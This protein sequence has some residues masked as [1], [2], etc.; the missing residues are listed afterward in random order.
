MRHYVRKL[1]R[2]CLLMAVAI[3]ATALLAGP[4]GAAEWYVANLG[5]DDTGDG[6]EGRPFRTIAQAWQAAL[7][8]R[9]PDTIYLRRG[10]T[11]T[12]SLSRPM[13]GRIKLGADPL[14][15]VVTFKPYGPGEARPTW[16]PENRKCI[17]T[18]NCR[19]TLEGLDCP[20]GA[21]Y[22]NTPDC[23]L[24][25]CILGGKPGGNF[26]RWH[27]S[28]DGLAVIDCVVR[29]QTN[30]EMHPHQ[31][32]MYHFDVPAR[33]WYRLTTYRAG[34]ATY[35]VVFPDGRVYEHNGTRVTFLE[36]GRQT[37]RIQGPFVNDLE[38]VSLEP[39]A[40]PD[41]R[42]TIQL[43]LVNPSRFL[44]LGEAINVRLRL[45]SDREAKL[46]VLA[47]RH[48][49]GTVIAQ[50]D[51]GIAPADLTEERIEFKVS[52]EG[53]VDI[54]VLVDGE[55]ANV[56]TVKVV[57]MDATPLPIPKQYTP[58]GEGTLVDEVDCG[59][60]PASL[61]RLYFD[62]GHAQVVDSVL[63]K[64]REAGTQ[65]GGVGHST[66][67]KN[68]FAYQLKIKHP[69]KLHRVVVDY[70]DDNYR[71]MLILLYERNRAFR[72]FDNGVG[73]GG[74]RPNTN[75]I[76][77]RE[78]FLY[79]RFEELFFV[80]HS[81]RKGA[82]AAI[83][84]IRVYEYDGD[85]PP[86]PVGSAE[87]YYGMY[88]EE[89]RLIDWSHQPSDEPIEFVNTLERLGQFMRHT[90][91]N[92]LWYPT[93]AY[94]LTTTE[95]EIISSL[96]RAGYWGSDL[97]RKTF[98]AFLLSA[99][100]H[101]YGIVA[102]LHEPVQR[103]GQFVAEGTP[104]RDTRQI[105]WDGRVG[106]MQPSGG[107]GYNFVHPEVQKVLLAGFRELA[108]FYQDCP[109]FMGIA[110]RSMRMINPAYVAWPDER[111]GYG[112]YT[113]G[114]F[115]QE[116]GVDVPVADDP[117]DLDR[118]KK[119]YDF[120]M[121][122]KKDEWFAWRAQK[123][124]EWLATIAE[125]LRQV[126]PDLCVF[127]NDAGGSYR[128]HPGRGM[129][130]AQWADIPNLRFAIYGWYG[131]QFAGYSF[132]MDHSQDI[133]PWEQAVDRFQWHSSHR[134][135]SVMNPYMEGGRLFPMYPKE[136]LEHFGGAAD[137]CGA[138][139]GVYPFYLQR[140]ADW[141]ST[142]DVWLIADGGL[143]YQ[144]IDPRPKQQFARFFR[145]LPVAEYKPSPLNLE[146]VFLWE[147][148]HKGK[149][150]FYVVNRQD[151][152]V[153]LTL[154]ISGPRTAK[155]LSDGQ[156]FVIKGER[157]SL[158]LDPYAMMAF[159]LSRRAQ[160]TSGATQIP[161][162]ELRALRRKIAQAWDIVRAAEGKLA[163]DK[164][165]QALTQQLG[166]DAYQQALLELALADQALKQHRYDTADRY[167]RGYMPTEART[168]RGYALPIVYRAMNRWPEGV[169]NDKSE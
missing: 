24:R 38:K 10:D 21:I 116:T 159:E 105:A 66:G 113:V 153:E 60:D 88:Y 118:F 89:P 41:P 50:R 99:E 67:S 13:P 33:G 131:P 122:E 25:D 110:F 127:M 17:T 58:L 16:G 52:E 45:G 163:D 87:R 72:Q 109:A 148:Q 92:L 5:N 111:W 94:G 126:R 138:P 46:S 51:I 120:L 123:V 93:S 155:R 112:D 137:T 65:A 43:A 162:Q 145:S 166:R 35:Q 90:G 18:G 135:I 141:M 129:D 56:E 71:A 27:R 49:D 1:R 91:Q 100:K 167:V 57:M 39:V 64:Y 84:R 136:M 86:L 104:I 6:S 70:P 7:G 26:G 157:L 55:P 20:S 134:A 78:I 53:Q 151:Y 107:S 156:E 44:R 164:Y 4:T 40:P 8:N 133:K 83:Q 74:V 115:E 119:R 73:T 30:V 81:W 19:V 3:S 47:R 146:P 22:A 165:A 82:P 59:A 132:P 11:F 79:P 152:P 9:E 14:P 121:N 2:L 36:A 97:G 168:S 68:W 42:E 124:T 77:Q 32:L 61:D 75:Q 76:Q 23:V 80:V 28:G 63:G 144:G 140:F 130:P 85:L 160:I 154:N 34:V 147:A 48:S 161:R 169:F 150:V 149:K 108:E 69:H 62:S 96:N 125:T 142:G 29:G 98:R 103:I 95:T 106:R 31:G 143:T 12:D 114:L 101:G 15:D 139:E 128:S 158:S 37:F 102:E 54:G 117:N